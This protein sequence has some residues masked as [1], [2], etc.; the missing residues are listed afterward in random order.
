MDWFER[1]TGFRES[2]YA[3]TGAKIKVEGRELKSLV[4]GK[5]YGIGELQLVS[6]Q[7]LRER[8][9]SLGGPAGRLKLAS[10]SGDVRRMHRLP[11]NADALFQ[12]A[13]QFNLLEMT[14]PEVTPEDGVTR[15]QHDP[16]QGPAC[17]IAAGAATIY[18][19]YFAPVE[20][21]LGQTAT[22]QLDGLADLG[23]ALAADLNRPVEA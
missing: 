11:A 17:A 21:S 22:R 12:V 16:T 6:L 13:S 2:N 9:V 14:S 10:V 19:N 20:R 3:D 5:S 1:L 23:V 4:N 7:S 8:V 15:Y 18:R